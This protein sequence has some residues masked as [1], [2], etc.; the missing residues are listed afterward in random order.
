MF[1]R[2][3]S[4]SLLQCIEPTETGVGP[5]YNAANLG[6]SLKKKPFLGLRTYISH[7]KN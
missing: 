6:M 5:R 3:F 7:L 4:K 2:K 1:V